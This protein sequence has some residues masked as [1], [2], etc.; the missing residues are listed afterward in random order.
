[1]L[2]RNDQIITRRAPASVAPK[3]FDEKARTFEA[4][5]ST[6]APVQ[7]RDAKGSFIERLDLSAIKPESLIGIAVLI[8]HQADDFESHVGT[9][10]AARFESGQLIASIKITADSLADSVVRKISEGILTGLSIGYQVTRF[11]ETIDN[12]QRVRTA[13]EWTVH[14]VSLVA[15]PADRDSKVRS[16][17]ATKAKKK[18]P[19]T[20]IEA[21]DDE[22]PVNNRTEIRSLVRAAKLKPEFADDLIDNDAT[23]DEAREAI[24]SQLER[25]SRIAALTVH[26]NGPSND[27]PTVIMARRADGLTARVMGTAPKDEA[28]EY[29]HESLASHA[30]SILSMRGETVRGMNDESVLTRAAQHTLSDFPNLLSATG[31]RILV[32]GYEAAPNVLKSLARKGTRSDFRTGSSLRIG[33]M[34]LLE[35]VTESGQVKSGTRGESKESYA[36]ATFAKMFSLSRAAIINDDLGAF[37]D[38]GLAMGR[39]ASETEAGQLIGLLTESNGAGPIMSDNKRLF[40]ADHGNLAVAGAAL[41]TTSLSAARLAMRSQKGVDGKT[42]INATP[43]ILLVSAAGETLGEQVLSEIAAATVA[44]ANPFSGKLTL[45]V[46]SRLS[47]AS[48]YVFADPANLPVLEY[49]YLSGA[50]GPQLASREGWDVLGQEFRV[51]LDFGAGAVDWR[52]GYRNAGA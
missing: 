35:K 23:V 50:E 9:V 22:S 52:G 5:I 8:E 49:A 10:T 19:E 11:I 21:D 17:M 36:L 2:K 20:E 40:H 43:K 34:G 30:R 26:S 13:V 33:E 37:R 15:I 16:T 45:L 25:R 18:A 51:L 3:T 46:D 7:R 6:G 48:W 12:G 44:D 24:T 38:W 1:M 29:V 28:R 31:Q 42:P 4:I 27:D 47:G 14:E 39:A 32:A 41:S